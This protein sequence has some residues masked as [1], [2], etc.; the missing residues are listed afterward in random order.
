MYAVVETQ[1]ETNVNIVEVKITNSLEE[2]IE[3]AMECFEDF[4][5]FNRSKNPRIYD[6]LYDDV[7]ADGIQEDQEYFFEFRFE[8][9]TGYTLH[10]VETEKL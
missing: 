10:I 1:M 8:N 2:A 7:R 3:Y 4:R 9:G 6:A 5:A